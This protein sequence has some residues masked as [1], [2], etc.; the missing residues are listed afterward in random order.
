MGKESESTTTSSVL[1]TPESSSE[2]LGVQ[3]AVSLK[4]PHPLDLDPSVYL[5]NDYVVID[6]ETTNLDHGN[7]ATQGNSL[8]FA[9]W[10]KGGGSL[11][12]VR[13]QE[14]VRG[15]FGNEY[16]QEELLEAINQ[17]S[18][19]V[20][21]HAKFECG[22]FKRCGVELRSLII[23]DP[24]LGEYVLAGNL[25]P[26]GGLSLDATLKRYG[27]DGKMRYVSALIESGTCPSRI[28]R[29]DLRTYGECDVRRTHD[30]FLQQRKRLFA[31]GRQR[32]FYGRCLQTP[33][34][35]DIESRGVHLDRERVQATRNDVLGEYARSDASLQE[36]TGDCNWDSPK[37]VGA[38]LYDKLGFQEAKDYRGR[39]IRTGGGGRSASVDTIDRLDAR[40][41]NQ[42]K[43]KALWN[44]LAPLKKQVSTLETMWKICEEAD[45]HFF[46]S[47]NQAVT[48]NHRLSSTGAKWGLQ[49]QNTAR[50]LK[51]LFRS[52]R[53]GCGLADGDCPQLEFR[54][55]VDLS[56]DPVGQEDILARADVHSLTSAVTGFSRQESKPHTFKPLYGGRSG[57][58][59]LRDYY[60]AFRN[61]YRGMYD[62]QMGWVYSV[63]ET[64]R[65][66]TATGLVFF[67]PDTSMTASGYITNTPSIFNYPIS[68][69]ATADISQISL[70]LTWHGIKG[71]DTH[72]VNTIHD[73]G[74]AD[75]PKEEACKFEQLMV[76]SYT[77]DVYSALD[78]LYGYRFN[79]P[80]GLGFK[81]GEFWTEGEER[82]YEPA[83]RFKFTSDTPTTIKLET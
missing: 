81:Y 59:R 47:F 80:L 7:P 3:G 42:R 48:Q 26:V 58:K 54:V 12:R 63:L 82:K 60:D 51:K 31:E 27:I 71:W 68:M 76:Q 43:F 10:V 67:W 34:L 29:G 1:S 24:M 25:K 79:T 21:Y 38:L 45:G 32:V 64:G 46:A 70:L 22:W 55:G 73:S 11:Q 20:A 39:V 62:H 65:L 61:R 77:S 72:I 66:L 23:Y 83:G 35:A 16:E 36:F 78:K 14:Q 37:Q 44:T 49:L 28:P 52:G 57:P 9:A 17:A 53:Q 2:R 19:V 50:S 74:V 41:T 40:T 18:F 75:V 8:V 69:F 13:G 33:M 6:F 30:L 56:G 5:R 15:H 4:K